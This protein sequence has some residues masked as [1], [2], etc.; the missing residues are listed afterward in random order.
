[1]KKLFAIA[2]VLV[3]VVFIVSYSVGLDVYNADGLVI[4]DGYVLSDGTKVTAFEYYYN[5]VVGFFV[6]P[7]EAFKDFFGVIIG[8]EDLGDYF[9]NLWGKIWDKLQVWWSG[10]IGGGAAA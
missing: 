7:L 4:S 5:K 10:I 3:I 2:M 8:G 6:Q 9:S 1:M